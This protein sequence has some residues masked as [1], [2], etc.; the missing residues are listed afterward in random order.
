MR[1]FED[2]LRALSAHRI[3]CDNAE[4]EVLIDQRAQQAGY[5]CQGCGKDF[6]LRN[7]EV[8]CDETFRKIQAQ[9]PSL[10]VED[11]LR[12]LY[13]LLKQY[14]IQGLFPSKGPLNRFEREDLV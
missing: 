9:K 14:G 11:R 13:E 8:A 10:K 7:R 4:A 1:T 12:F 2:V 6:L 5:V 3:R